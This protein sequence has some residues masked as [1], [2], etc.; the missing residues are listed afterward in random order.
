MRS[1][2]LGHEE[3]DRVHDECAA[4]LTAAL[5][6]PDEELAAQV[7]VLSRHLADHFAMEDG[8]MDRTEFPARACHQQEHAAVLASC[9]EVRP[10]VAAGKLGVG[11]ALVH[12]I[13]EWFPAHAIHL[14]SALAAWICKQNAG[15]KPLVF[16]RARAS[17]D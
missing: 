16:H 1:Q 2:P 17:A 11:R 9:N 13:G 14:D 10:L 3:I 12:A 8:L 5:A 15:G 6:C 4:L 7:D